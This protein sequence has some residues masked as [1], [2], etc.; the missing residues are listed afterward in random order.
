[1]PEKGLSQQEVTDFIDKL[2]NTSN[3]RTLV[4]YADTSAG[5]GFTVI[6]KLK[7]LGEGV[8]SVQH[9]DDDKGIT[10]ASSFNTTIADLLRYPCLF[11]DPREFENNPRG[12]EF[13]QK[14]VP[15]NFGLAFWI[16]QRGVLSLMQVNLPNP[17]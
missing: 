13:F 16:P 17:T 8:L 1:M 7:S 4:I 6:G 14:E 11:T 2:C 9:E 15:F 12:K 10:D 5:F 3:T